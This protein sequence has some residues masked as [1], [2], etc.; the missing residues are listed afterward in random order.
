MQEI[1]WEVLLATTPVRVKKAELC[2]KK[3]LN[4]DAVA[5]E[6][7]VSFRGYSGPSEFSQI[8]TRGLGCM[9][10]LIGWPLDRESNYIQMKVFS[11]DTAVSIQQSAFPEDGRM[12]VKWKRGYYTGCTII[13]TTVNPLC[14]SNPL[15]Y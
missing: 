15:I 2:R 14:Y 12:S 11:R 4:Y 10:P 13:S 1:C 9:W 8:K 5:T 7:S 6:A 3:S